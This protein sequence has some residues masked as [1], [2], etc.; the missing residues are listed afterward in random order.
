MYNEN[1]IKGKIVLTATLITSGL[2]SFPALVGVPL[3]VK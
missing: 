1:K 3:K 2:F